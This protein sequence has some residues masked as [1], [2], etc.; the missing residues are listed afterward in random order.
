VIAGV[1][2][3]ALLGGEC[4]LLLAFSEHSY[5]AGR[6]SSEARGAATLTFKVSLGVTL[7]PCSTSQ[8]TQLQDS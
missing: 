5:K 8:L 6:V 7:Y 2:V 4:V 3:L 1:A